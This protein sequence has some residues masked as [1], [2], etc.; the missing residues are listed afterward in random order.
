MVI[1]VVLGPGAT[2]IATM[3]TS[4]HGSHHRSPVPERLPLGACGLEVFPLTLGGNTFGWTADQERSFEILDAYH[5]AGGNFV[6]TAD[7]YSRWG[8]GLH[9]GESETVL[10]KW[11]RSRGIAAGEVIVATKAGKLPPYDNLRAESIMKAC[12][13]S[14][15]RLQLETIELYYLHADDPEVPIADQVETMN[16]LIEAGKIRYVGLSNF[17]ANRAREFFRIA[18]GTPA[19]PVAIQPHYNLIHRAEVEGELKPVID[20]FRPALL[21]YFSLASGILTGKYRSAAELEGTPR[22]RFTRGALTEDVLGVIT[23][24]EQI[25][26]LHDVAVSTVAL[27]WLRAHGATAPIASASRPEQ[28]GALLDSALLEL[29]P[30]EVTSLDAASAAFA[31]ADHQK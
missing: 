28:L 25:A 2:I 26:A 29:S 6:D 1:D 24:L 11:M 8:E 16:Q 18:R 4:P 10:G 7:V 30:A 22:A 12:E 31:A 14:L 27:S 9:G 17:P 3:D 15:S 20:E 5:A 23:R 21:P 13:D 19:F